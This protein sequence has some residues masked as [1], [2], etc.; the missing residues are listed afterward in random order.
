MA[1]AIARATRGAA[2]RVAAAPTVSSREDAAPRRRWPTAAHPLPARRRVHTG[3]PCADAHSADATPAPAG[4]PTPSPANGS[5]AAPS[6]P[7]A[8]ADA[9]DPAPAEGCATAPRP[10]APAAPRTDR[11][12]VQ[13]T[14]EAL[15][16]W[17]A[18]APA[19][20]AVWPVATASS[21]PSSL[22][23]LP[24]SLAS[25]PSS[26]ASLPSSLASL[27]S[28]LASLPS[29]A[30][31]SASALLSLASTKAW[32]RP[33]W[34]RTWPRRL[35]DETRSLRHDVDRAVS[36]WLLQ[37]RD[38][39]NLFTG[40]NEIAQL[41]EHVL[42]SNTA[43]EEARAVMTQSKQAYEAAIDRRKTV[44]RTLTSLLQR[45]DTW[46]DADVE[47]FTRVY[48]EDVATEAAE[49]AARAAYRQAE[50]AFDAAHVTYLNAIRE[51]YM[52]EQLYSDK[53]RRA[54]TY[55]TWGLLALQI[56]SLVVVHAYIEP[57]KRRRLL[58]ALRIQMTEH[59]EQTQAT[60]DAGLR[61]QTAQIQDL[62]A[63]T[64]AQTLPAVMTGAVVLTTPSAPTPATPATSAEETATAEAL[65]AP[66]EDPTA[67]PASETSSTSPRTRRW[68]DWLAV[69]RTAATAAATGRP[70]P[71]TPAVLAPPLMLDS[72]ALLRDPVWQHG[73]AVG[74]AAASLL[75]ALIGR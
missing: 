62:T 43:L 9:A 74:A 29:S 34:P 67:A 52:Q 12:W 61:A 70:A 72:P 57:G 55:W 56:L 2:R 13:Q 11:P 71:Q 24:S 54:A 68:Y 14:L 23:S 27:P 25:L 18:R 48:R 46:V 38:A 20:A 65:A 16:A 4:S 22:A 3:Q 17:R 73:I 28:S 8:T 36:P 30:S 51:R 44:A 37:A 32:P 63:E 31:A 59:M 42:A 5:P 41:K 47:S 60:V 58:E 45:K 66:S 21:L 15:Q 10:A 40:F 35:T 49:T 19:R 33:P 50:D 69:D 75:F 64:V 26:L 7:S 1:T 53:I 39:L 6:I